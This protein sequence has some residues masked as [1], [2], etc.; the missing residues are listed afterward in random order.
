MITKKIISQADSV[1]SI[2]STYEP[3]ILNHC[4]ESFEVPKLE[5]GPYKV[6]VCDCDV[7]II[8]IVHG[9]EID[10]ALAYYNKLTSDLLKYCGSSVNCYS[11]F[12]KKWFPSVNNI[13]TL[14]ARDA[15]RWHEVL[16][17]IEMSLSPFLIDRNESAQRYDLWLRD[18]YCYLSV[19]DVDENRRIG[20]PTTEKLGKVS[21]RGDLLRLPFQMVQN[22]G[23]SPIVNLWTY[24]TLMSLA[25]AFRIIS[26]MVKNQRESIVI[27]G[28]HHE[29]QLREYLQSPGKLYHHFIDTWRFFYDQYIQLYPNQQNEITLLLTLN[30][31]IKPE[32]EITPKRLVKFMTDNSH[33][34]SS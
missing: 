19:S 22:Q 3:L 17:K 13:S 7:T 5:E 33:I 10:R 15:E 2:F 1:A 9:L 25:M 8:G 27:C 12:P 23:E 16:T 21:C 28:T 24:I 26:G 31:C 20:W 30:D 11:E 14:I 18:P 29:L 32:E 6:H 4:V 34:F